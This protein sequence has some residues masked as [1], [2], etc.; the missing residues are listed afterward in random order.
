MSFKLATAVE[1]CFENI[2]IRMGVSKWDVEVIVDIFK[3]IGSNYVTI[4]LL[5]TMICLLSYVVSNDLNPMALM[6]LFV[7]LQAYSLVEIYQTEKTQPKNW[8]DLVS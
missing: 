6:T 2:L 5:F 8:I 3:I 4:L 1:T 7:F